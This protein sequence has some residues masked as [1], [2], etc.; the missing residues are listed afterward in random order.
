MRFTVLNEATFYGRTSYI[1]ADGGRAIAMVSV[2]DNDRG[3]ATLHDLVVH[4]SRR[5]AGIGSWM[6][7]K[8]Q[9]VA[10]HMGADSMTLTSEPD[11]WQADWYRR[12][13]FKDVGLGMYGGHTVL[14][15]EKKLE[16]GEPRGV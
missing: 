8:A 1:V 11:S 12:R 6:L 10:W 2:F 4:D 15:M 3:V 7:A 16:K 5:R 14:V 9:D 13:G